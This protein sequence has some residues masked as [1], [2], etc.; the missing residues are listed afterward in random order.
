MQETKHDTIVSVIIPCYNCERWIIKCLDSIKN[1]TFSQLEVVCIDDCSKD[2]TA[3]V[4][5]DY[6]QKST[7]N[8]KL[9][10]N[11]TNKGPALS[12]NIASREA[13]GE[14]LVF[15][16]ADDF[17]DET[18]IEKMYTT[19]IRE[20]SDMPSDVIK[21]SVCFCGCPNGIFLV[22]NSFFNALN[23]NS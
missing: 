23:V 17:Y 6:A 20:N 21:P 22:S 10:K 3:S 13:V 12:R 5:E 11:E 7:L 2:G 15:C 19:A 1:Q 4:I 18:F 8:V 14:F 16:D 9:I